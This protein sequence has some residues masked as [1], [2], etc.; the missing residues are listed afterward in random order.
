MQAFFTVGRFTVATRLQTALALAKLSFT[1]LCIPM[2]CL[3]RDWTAFFGS[4]R[5]EQG[6]GVLTAC[7]PLAE[8]KSNFLLLK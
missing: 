5:V 3:L 2:R 7:T 4:N 1:G 8:K 6:T